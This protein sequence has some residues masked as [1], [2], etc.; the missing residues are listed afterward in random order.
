MMLLGDLAAAM[1][2]ELDGSHS[3]MPVT[4]AT[5]DSRLAGPGTLFFALPGSRTDGHLYVG[6]VLERGGAAV[7]SR[8]RGEGPAIRVPDVGRALLD[9]AAWRRS[10]IP[11][12][13]IG[14]TGSSGKT[15]TK[16]LLGEALRTRHTVAASPGNMNNHIGMPLTLLNIGEPFPDVIVLELG[17]NHA[18]EL[19][20]LGGVARPHHSLVTSIGRAHME[21]F[22]DRD[23][24]AAAKAELLLATPQGGR[25]V[26]P[27]GEPVLEEAAGRAG[28]RVLRV[29]EGG[30]AWIATDPKSGRPLAM[31][32]GLEVDLRLPG[33]HN[34]RNALTAMLMAGELDVP[35]DAALEAMARVAP[36]EGRGRSFVTSSGVRILDESYNSNPDSLR[37]CL[38]HLAGFEGERACVLGDMYELGRDRMA[39]HRRALAHAD[40]LGL[41]FVILTG[42]LFREA[43]EEL[44]RTKHAAVPD[45]E[46]ALEEL[47]RRARPGMTVLVKGSNSVGLGELVRALEVDR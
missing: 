43:G 44:R 9:A 24:L 4:G 7:V 10:R 23:A 20:I 5:V 1:G 27:T 19:T 34:L 14:L 31:P 36:L 12:V 3:G 46:A 47:R 11:S 37:A 45:W 42:Y 41:S 8:S 26:I 16:E 2:G 30:D 38:D 22:E 39:L 6:D 15:T 35:P 29:G 25:C 17:M 13:V 32:E 33:P 21:F 40:G 18:G 28:L